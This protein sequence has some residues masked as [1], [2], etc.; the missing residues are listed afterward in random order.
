MLG[1]VVHFQNFKEMIDMH[2]LICELM[3][4]GPSN[5][6]QISYFVLRNL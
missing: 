4:Y 1:V 5:V 3:Q 2:A 6:Y